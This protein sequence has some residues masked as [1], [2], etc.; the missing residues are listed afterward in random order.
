MSLNTNGTSPFA[1][2][3][4]SARLPMGEASPIMDLRTLAFTLSPDQDDRITSWFG[5]A[6]LCV[7]V[8]DAIAAGDGYMASIVNSVSPDALS[9]LREGVEVAD[10]EVAIEVGRLMFTDFITIADEFS[11]QRPEMV[12]EVVGLFQILMQGGAQ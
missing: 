8:G 7:T 11:R 4:T 9:A 10:P 3:L 2:Q 6:A 1:L 12:A 5:A